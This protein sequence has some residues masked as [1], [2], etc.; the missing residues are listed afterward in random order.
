MFTMWEFWV[1]VGCGIW[2]L[3]LLEI[4]YVIFVNIKQGRGPD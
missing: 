2:F 4:G 1:G 3:V